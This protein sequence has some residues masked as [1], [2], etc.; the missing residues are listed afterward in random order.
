MI[1]HKN[2]L[3][4]FFEGVL[5]N[6]SGEGGI[7]T[8]GTVSRTTVFETATIDRSATSPKGL[9]MSVVGRGANIENLGHFLQFWRDWGKRN[10]FAPS[11]GWKNVNR[12][13]FDHR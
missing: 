9:T 5:A 8:L 12:Y 7:R 10:S 13:R 11:I 3:K 6:F 1:E 2:A 4:L